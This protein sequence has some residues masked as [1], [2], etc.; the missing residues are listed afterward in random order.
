MVVSVKKKK[1]SCLCKLSILVD[2][3]MCNIQWIRI[4]AKKKF[5]YFQFNF[6]SYA[7]LINIGLPYFFC[8]QSL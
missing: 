2:K 8:I 7:A 4:C 3:L 5:A 1:L 6:Y